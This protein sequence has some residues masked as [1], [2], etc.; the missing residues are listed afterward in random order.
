MITSPPTQDAPEIRG[1]VYRVYTLFKE[2]IE[3]LREAG[4]PVADLPDLAGVRENMA[5]AVVEANGRIVAYW[6]LFYALHAEPLFIAPEWRTHPAVVKGI[7][8]GMLEEAGKTG[9][10]AIYASI[11]TEEVEEYGARLGFTPVPGRLWEMKL[12]KE[13]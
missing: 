2:D 4:G 1:G 9:E 11:E 8:K 6:C 13:N 7:V 5:V 12:P 3:R 10:G